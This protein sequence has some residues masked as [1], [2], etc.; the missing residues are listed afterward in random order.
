MYNVR[1]IFIYIIAVVAAV[2]IIAIAATIL[3]SGGF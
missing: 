3:L 1:R 2:L